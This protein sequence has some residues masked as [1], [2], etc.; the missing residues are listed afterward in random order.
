MPDPD[1]IQFPFSI[2][3][4]FDLFNPE[5]RALFDRLVITIGASTIKELLCEHAFTQ[6]LRN[7]LINS[8]LTGLCANPRAYD[9]LKQDELAVRTLAIADAVLS[10]L[11]S[12]TDREG[13][14]S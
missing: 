10:L 3:T 12:P 9:D 11:T 6:S 8:A 1:L 4:P 13:K 5:H 7:S 2:P 14:T